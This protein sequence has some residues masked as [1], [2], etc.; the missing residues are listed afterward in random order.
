MSFLQLSKNVQ[1]KQKK[2]QKIQWK[3]N[4]TFFL[5]DLVL[6]RSRNHLH[7]SQTLLNGYCIKKGP[8]LFSLQFSPFAIFLYLAISSYA[9]RVYVRVRKR[10]TC[11][12]KCNMIKS[13]I[14]HVPLFFVMV[15]ELSGNEVTYGGDRLLLLMPPVQFLS[16][17]C[18]Q[19]MTI[20]VYIV[21]CVAVT[22]LSL[23]Y[24]KAQREN[25]EYILYATA[26]SS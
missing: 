24:T 13:S 23:T 17:L 4:V 26:W 5:V 21:F 18:V 15:I 6:S 7:S 14:S 8:D 9:I 3:F 12:P 20:S 2:W 16:Q 22:V 1:Q 10:F 11:N 25:R 19:C